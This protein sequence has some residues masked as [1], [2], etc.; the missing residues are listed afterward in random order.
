MGVIIKCGVGLNFVCILV[1]GNLEIIG[2]LVWKEE[3]WEKLL[4]ERRFRFNTIYYFLIVRGW[5]FRWGLDI[6]LVCRVWNFKEVKEIY[7]RFVFR[8]RFLDIEGLLVSVL[9]GNIKF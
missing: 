7:G 2:M 4:V 8:L 6:W 3:C 5:F 9:L 1:F